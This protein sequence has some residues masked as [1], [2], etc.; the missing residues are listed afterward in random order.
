MPDIRASSHSLEC[1]SQPPVQLP[2][3]SRP[4]LAPQPS[5][6]SLLTH[7]IISTSQVPPLL[8]PAWPGKDVLPST[9]VILQESED[10]QGEKCSV[11]LVLVTIFRPQSRL[12]GQG[13]G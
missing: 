7:I 12:L 2:R 6:T 4:L 8:H 13:E 9:R 10:G 3:S 11:S 5:L 1:H